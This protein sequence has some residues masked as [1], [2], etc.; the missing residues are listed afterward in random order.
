MK[1]PPGPAGEAGEDGELVRHRELLKELIET[2]AA[3]G[4][5]TPEEQIRLASQLY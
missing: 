4:S 1:G 5:I 2:L 3:K